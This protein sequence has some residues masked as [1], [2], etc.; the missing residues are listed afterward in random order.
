MSNL[1]DQKLEKLWIVQECKNQM[2]RYE[3]LHSAKKHKD[4][5]ELF[6]LKKPD[7]W[8]ENYDLGFFKGAEGIKRFFVDFH[9]AMDGDDISGSFCQHDLTTEVIVVADDLKTAKAVWMSPG[10]ETRRNP[11]TG[12]LTSFWCWVKYAVDFIEED[13]EWKFWHFTIFSDFFCDYHTA[14]VDVP[15]ITAATDDMLAPDE[16]V[17]VSLVYTR[18]AIPAYWPIPPTPYET[19]RENTMTPRKV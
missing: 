16:E 3:Y 11:E 19:Y 10:V 1:L 7:C 4:T 6:A 18:N 9:I 5:Y 2:G 14:W 8:I 13:G 17:P 15:Y 12:A